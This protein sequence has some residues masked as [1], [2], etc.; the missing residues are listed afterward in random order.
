MHLTPGFLNHTLKD[1]G[2]MVGVGSRE[3]FVE[4]EATEAIKQVPGGPQTAPSSCEARTCLELF[5]TE[6]Q[7]HTQTHTHTLKTTATSKGR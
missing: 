1:S 5:K 7:K 4:L 6:W 3:A 2:L